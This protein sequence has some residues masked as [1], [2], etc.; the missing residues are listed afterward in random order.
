MSLSSFLSTNTSLQSS[1]FNLYHFMQVC[2]NTPVGSSIQTSFTIMCVLLLAPFCIFVLYLVHQQTKQQGSGLK[3][4]HADVFTLH[5]VVIELLSIFGTTL[6]CCGH[7]ADIPDMMMLGIYFYSLNLP[8]QMFFHILTCLERFVA[9]VHPIAYLSM[10]TAKGI[11][12]RNIAVCCTWLLTFVWTLVL[13]TSD[14]AA[15]S[16][17]SFCITFLFFII[18]SSCSLSV[19][20]VLIR[21]GPG[22][23][24]GERRV[25]HSKMRAFYTILAILGVLLFRFGGTTLSSSA[26]YASAELTGEGRCELWLSVVWFYLP[27]R[28]VLPIL[29]LQRVGKLLCCRN[30]NH[31]G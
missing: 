22:E 3:L 21:P 4:S 11:R 2:Y 16:S 23:G 18:V 27:S 10:R 20:C 7:H 15:I 8:G 24:G 6:I 13:I 14:Q 30:R 17:I 28:L 19:L 29:F 26:T 12:I 5:V 9:V 1:A 31:S 25:D